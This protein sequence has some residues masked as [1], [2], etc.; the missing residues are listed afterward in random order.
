M[1][2]GRTGYKIFVMDR[3]S[4][5]F[6]ACVSI[7][8]SQEYSWTLNSGLHCTKCVGGLDLKFLFICRIF[9]LTLSQ[10]FMGNVNEWSP[11]TVPL[12]KRY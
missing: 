2:P 10:E 5:Y 1:I 11:L 4:C 9:V 8:E 7:L 3:I 6:D 12:L